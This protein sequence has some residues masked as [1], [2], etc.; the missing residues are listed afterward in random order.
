MISSN[1]FIAMSI[2]WLFSKAVYFP[3]HDSIGPDIRFQSETTVD[4]AFRTHPPYWQHSVAPNLRKN[5][6]LKMIMWSHHMTTKV[7]L[8][9]IQERTQVISL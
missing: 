5:A 9:K 1:L 3:Q 6:F 4:Y 2:V 8:L 7:Y